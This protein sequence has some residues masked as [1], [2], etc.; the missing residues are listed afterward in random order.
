MRLGE[1]DLNKDV[2]CDNDLCSDN[3]LDVPIKRLI[4]H[5]QYK[6]LSTKQEHDIALIRL[7]KTVAFTRW[8]RPIC[9]PFRDEL[10]NK[11]YDDI[12]MQVAGWGYTSSDRN[13]KA[14]K[15]RVN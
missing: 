9:L 2:D 8:I 1:W 7:A 6:P 4:P 14:Y 10:K 13:G 12:Y 5:E 15:L 3:V 11:N